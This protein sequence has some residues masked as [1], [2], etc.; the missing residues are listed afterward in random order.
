VVIETLRS[1]KPSKPEKPVLV[2]G[3]PEQISRKDRQKNGIP[4]NRNLRN[5]IKE[6]AQNAKVEYLLRNNTKP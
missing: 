6:I 2:P 3:E 4:V 1:V 5:L